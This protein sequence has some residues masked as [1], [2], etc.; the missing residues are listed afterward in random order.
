[1]MNNQL[2][3]FALSRLS[4]SCI[5]RCRHS[6]LS[7][8][9]SS[10]TTS[11]QAARQSLNSRRSV[12]SY[13]SPPFSRN[14]SSTSLSSSSTSTTLQRQHRQE[15]R[16]LII[17][18]G[19]AGCSAAL[20]AAKAGIPVTI[21]HAGRTAIDCNS[22]W[23]QGGIIYR[24]YNLKTPPPTSTP[25]TT[26]A[27]AAVASSTA[28]TVTSGAAAST[29][30]STDAATKSK[31]EMVDSI[32]WENGYAK[33]NTNNTKS[34]NSDLVDTTISLVNDIR[35]A[36][37]YVAPL[38]RNNDDTTMLDEG[39]YTKNMHVNNTTTLLSSGSGGAAA[40][41]V[42]GD[43]GGGS[44]DVSELGR[45]CTI[46]GVTWNEDAAWKL[47]LEGPTRVRQLLLG[48]VDFDS[49]T[50]AA[51]SSTATAN[52]TTTNNITT[53]NAAIEATNVGGGT[54]CIIDFDRSSSGSNPN[55]DESGLSLCLEASHSAPRIIHQADRTGRAITEGITATA[56]HHPLITFMS[57]SIVVDLLY[58]DNN[59]TDDAI[60]VIGARILDT[61]TNTITINM[62]YMV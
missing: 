15:E 44:E 53:N 18:S 9:K 27:T 30:K 52:N 57:D 41:R 16:L 34:S 51:A 24:N 55:N 33:W 2:R 62:Q 60:I 58:D 43:D 47:A 49:T 56:A 13:S 22:Y 46:S 8:A 54:R 14:A 61:K 36:S 3:R 6:S 32:V 10:A 59:E 40:G 25:S 5:R 39:L 7:D 48:H 50:T 12:I 1:M 29:A 37:G 17:G 45:K 21:I 38:Q 28:P 11:A 4:P 23:A 19:V 20:T 26:T 42:D 31:E 35:L